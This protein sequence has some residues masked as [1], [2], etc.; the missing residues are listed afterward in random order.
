MSETNSLKWIYNFTVW[1]FFLAVFPALKVIEAE[2]KMIWENWN[3][4]K[5][6][7]TQNKVKREVVRICKETSK[8]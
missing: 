1:Q 4:E 5:E 6:R 2:D 3:L 8:V 7:I